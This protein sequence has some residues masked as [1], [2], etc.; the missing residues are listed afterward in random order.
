MRVSLELGFDFA[1]L[2]IMWTCVL[3]PPIIYV[4]VYVG[5]CVCVCV[6]VYVYT[7]TGATHIHSSRATASDVPDAVIASFP[8]P[9]P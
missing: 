1:R 2:A 9:P 6:H 5:I 3:T 8:S 4:F 7:D